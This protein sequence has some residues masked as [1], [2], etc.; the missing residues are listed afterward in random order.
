VSLEPYPFRR[1][2]LRVSI[3]TRQVPKRLYTDSLD[4]QKTLARAPYSALNFTLRAGNALCATRFA[5]A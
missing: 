1:A 2:P 4:L 5:V 3:L